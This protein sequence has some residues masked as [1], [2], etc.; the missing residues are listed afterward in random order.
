MI[1]RGGLWA[2]L[3][4]L[5]STRAAMYL[6]STV[7]ASAGGWSHHETLLRRAFYG[8]EAKEEDPDR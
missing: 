5:S 2:S 8:P 4:V 7:N 6:E 3:V 1:V